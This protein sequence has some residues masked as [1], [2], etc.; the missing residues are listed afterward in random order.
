MWTLLRT[1]Y[2]FLSWNFMMINLSLHDIMS[3]AGVKRKLMTCA[4]ISELP[5]DIMSPAGVKRKLM[6]CAS[7]SEL[8]YDTME[9]NTEKEK[10]KI[11]GER[12]RI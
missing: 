4:S 6:T 11:K 9:E 7:I 3:P 1:V 2:R 8:P 5:Y 12:E 10:K